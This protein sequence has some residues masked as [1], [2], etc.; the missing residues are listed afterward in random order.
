ML[1]N[2]HII[3]VEPIYDGNLGSIA[4]AMK[5]SGLTKLILVKPEAD[6]KGSMARKMSV[7]AYDI[8]K[9]AEIYDSLDKA[10]SDFEYL[11]GTT[12]RK[13]AASNR[14]FTAKGITEN[15][16]SLSKK[17]KIG[18]MFGREDSGL[19]NDELSYVNDIVN[20]PT[21]SRLTS[22]NISQA[23]MIMGYEIY[24]YHNKNGFSQIPDYVPASV[25][26]KEYLFKRGRKLLDLINFSG[27]HKREEIFQTLKYLLN[28]AVPSKREVDIIQGIIKE[29][30]NRIS[31]D[32]D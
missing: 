16:L 3:L 29:V 15:L 5:N 24:Q 26:R 23:V 1:K 11:V 13:R 30:N 2:I 4:R 22:L 8:L 31:E 20:I 6:I 12:N 32:G 27:K 10:L 18:I 9:N 7:S 28:R 17:N 14:Y 25:E 19:T 21:S